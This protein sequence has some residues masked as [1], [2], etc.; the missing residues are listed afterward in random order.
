MRNMGGLRNRMKLT[1]WVYLIGALALGG[2]P[3]LAGFWSKDEILGDAFSINTAVYW[4]LA[5]T[6]FLTAFYMGRQVLMVFFGDPRTG[7]ATAARESAPLM[8]IPLAVLATLSLLGGALNFPGVHSLSTWLEHT[9]A[10]IHPSEFNLLLA[11]FSAFLALLA[12]FISWLLYSKRYQAM[13]KLPPAR[14]V[15]DPLR[16]I[17]GPVFTAL[18]HKWWV[19]E[20][21]SALILNPYKSL[22]RL[23]ITGEEEADEK[24]FWEYWVHEVALVGGFRAISDFLAL[25]VD[26]EVID[27]TFNGLAEATRW[28]ASKLR[29]IQ[30]GYVRNY[31]LSMFLGVVIIVGY[32]LIRR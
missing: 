11:G 10:S 4:L 23:M 5:I 3:P 28:V 19:D 31:A 1:F 15:D 21:Y 27:A 12:I 9:I 16:Q 14:R 18:E 22:A 8:T 6:A 17:I 7:A 26:L 32:L 20:F 13:L 30:T 2:V 29:R 25:I 24:E